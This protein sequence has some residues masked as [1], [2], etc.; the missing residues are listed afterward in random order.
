M[1]SSEIGYFGFTDGGCINNGKKN[2]KA[3]FCSIAVDGINKYIITELVQPNK[4]YLDE[5]NIT[6]NENGLIVDMAK[7]SYTEASYIK[8][9]NTIKINPSSNRGELLGLIHCFAQ[10]VCMGL[11]KDM[12]NNYIEVYTDSLLCVNT[13][14][15]WLLTRQK[16]NTTHKMKNIDLITIADMFFKQLKHMYK[17]VKLLHTK[18]HQPRPD[19]SKGT[20]ALFIWLG[21]KHADDYCSSVLN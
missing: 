21:N 1:A 8:I 15:I 12:S 10:L 16:N 17:S 2:A 4:Y 19:I 9:D 11:N 14:N 7:I 18:S 20:K 6:F 13:L 5:T 3:S